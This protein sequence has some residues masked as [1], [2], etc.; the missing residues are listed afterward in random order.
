MNTYHRDL[1]PDNVLVGPA[2][3]DGLK[4]TDYGLA[5]FVD[6]NSTAGLTLGKGTAGYMAREMMPGIG[7]GHYDGKVSSPT[8]AIIRLPGSCL[9]VCHRCL[10]MFDQ[11][12][13]LLRW[14]CSRSAL[15]YT[16]RWS[17]T[18]LLVL[19]LQSEDPCLR[20]S[21]AQ[22]GRRFR[23]H[24][25]IFAKSALPNFVGWSLVDLGVAGCFCTIQHNVLTS[26]E[27]WRI[28]F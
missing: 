18:H 14:T 11:R 4:V 9:V 6:P 21:V 10:I 13:A 24:A 17:S 26:T 1:K 19:K 20:I 12:F 8:T 7:D 28:H 16:P 2:G 15:S 23:G 25:K 5:R 27:S 3:L 22:N